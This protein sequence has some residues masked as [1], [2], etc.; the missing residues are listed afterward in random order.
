[1]P[2][3]EISDSSVGVELGDLVVEVAVLDER[4]VIVAV[5]DAWDQFAAD[6]G[7]EAAAC[8]VGASYLAACDGAGDDPAAMK[9]AAALR[10]ALRGDLEAA[11]VVEIACHSPDEER[12]F[13]VTISAR[14]NE[15]GDGIGAT[16]MLTAVTERKREQLTAEEVRDVRELRFRDAVTEVI[17]TTRD[18]TSVSDIY[19]AI[20]EGA[21][22]VT[23]A[24]SA[25]LNLVD[26]TGTDGVTV[27][28]AGFK[29]D[30]L[31]GTR[32]PLDTSMSGQIL[33]TGKSVLIDDAGAHQM[34]WQPALDAGQ[35][36]SVVAT[37]LQGVG[38]VLGANT[39][40]GSATFTDLDLDFLTRYAT[41]AAL[42]L[43]TAQRL[44]GD[45]NRKLA[46]Q[47][48][49]PA[50]EVERV[51]LRPLS[52]LEETEAWAMV[53]SSPDGMILADEHGTMVLVNAQIETLF[54]YD[55]GDLLGRSVEEL[56]PDRHRQIHTAHRTR[57]RAQPKKRVMGSGLD[58]KARRSDGTEF[59]VEV[60]LSPVT[61]PAGLRVVATVRDVSDRLA[62]EAFN[63]TVQHAINA[64][65]DGLLMFMPDTLE[66]T[67]VNDGAVNQL[68]YSRD[69]LLEM[70]PLHIK[71]DFTETQFRELLQPLLDGI[72]D[73]HVFTTV[74]RRKD[75]HDLPVE[76][77][78]QYP[79]AIADDQPRMLVALVRDITKR[80][81]A[82]Q[83]LAASEA[84][85]RT[86]FNAGPVGM[87]MVDFTDTV[88]RPIS[89]CNT[90]L[91][92]LLG[93]SKAEMLTKGFADLTHPDDAEQSHAS[94]QLAAAGK[95]Q[96]YDLEK[97]YLH[98]DGHAVWVWVHSAVLP[99]A[100]GNPTRGMVHVADL[101]ARKQAD[102][103]KER[104]RLWLAALSEIRVAVLADSPVDQT[105]ELVCI[106]AR[107]L[108]AADTAF[109]ARADYDAGVVR[110]IACDS[111]DTQALV[112][113]HF[114]I[115]EAVRQILDGKSFLTGR[116]DNDDRVDEANR[117]FGDNDEVTAVLAVP[118][119]SGSS[120]D[121]LL[122]ISHRNEDAV[123]QEQRATIESFA[124]E[125]ATAIELHAARQ[126]QA[127]LE[128]L[129]DRE[130]LA[131][132]LHD[133]VIQRLFA[134]GMGLQSVFSLVQ[135]PKARDRLTDTVG[136]LDKTIAELRSAIFRLNTAE[137]TNVADKLRTITQSAQ[138][139]LH[140]QPTL[141][142]HG[143]P[144]A[145]GGMVLEQL[146]PTLTEA[147]SNVARH[148]NA[149][150][151]TVSLTIEPDTVL[152]TVADNGNGIDPK[153]ARG[154]GL[155]N[156]ESRAHRANGTATI[157]ANPSGT[158]AMLIWQAPL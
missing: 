90:A 51:D 56:L 70:T 140:F 33:Q 135:D 137:A 12:W 43:Q 146:Y 71:P 48:L 32:V 85:F 80:V 7:G 107:N 26:E 149:S 96:Q 19:Q 74:H 131:Q 52:D 82:V 45:D 1:M 133:V 120:A 13:D 132:D 118:I 144:D 147:L 150:A 83:A 97:R 53:E 108:I 27:A 39:I 121:A 127:R 101:T 24:D 103:E 86:A 87:A 75:G 94:A 92:E 31:L 44:V 153:A 46:T 125:A 65:R 154:K 77:V 64:T 130:R 38:G 60:S 116:L 105:L 55:R 3:L 110:V 89:D 25:V 2:G 15:T 68:G 62:A 139:Q 141:E 30:A 113:D 119:R 88:R 106:H 14:T 21:R 40:H 20:V 102:D 47:S 34:V 145:I 142:I 23:D 100:E 6:N 138:D 134:A 148:A 143:D 57:Y 112:P 72:T 114:V 98:A 129:Q 157:T 152:L 151:V 36:K 66:F 11:A 81:E 41:I 156:I 29:A 5:N 78:L 9:V 104:S 61:T 123:S 4:G 122:A 109:I 111:P 59:P 50:R 124:H 126:T 8:G 73:S 63:H 128:V 91:C 79:P 18:A 115:D 58:L 117:R 16:V 37:P 76:I 158:G 49:P 22:H 95:M 17:A 84:A 155:D 42:S 67:Y 99:D 10:T 136:Q 69:D 93:Y 28:A 54:G 35:I